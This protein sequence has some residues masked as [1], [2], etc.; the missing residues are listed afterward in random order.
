[1]AVCPQCSSS[2]MT[3]QSEDREIYLQYECADLVTRSPLGKLIRANITTNNTT[4]HKI[5]TVQTATH[6]PRSHRNHTDIHLL[7]TKPST[8]TYK[9]KRPNQLH[10][11]PDGS[12]RI[13][14][15]AIGESA[16]CA[17]PR[18]RMPG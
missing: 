11:T 10:T 9:N 15:C 13:E 12:P 8:H 16:V 17:A 4:Q 5:T 14:H 3:L 1:M 18:E 2:E 6:L 7:P